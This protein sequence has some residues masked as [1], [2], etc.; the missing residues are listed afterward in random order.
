MW[1]RNLVLVNRRPPIPSVVS[2]GENAL[3]IAIV[4]GNEAMVRLLCE[5]CPAVLA[6][7]AVGS[8]FAPSGTCY[9]GELPLSFAVCTNQGS[10]VRLL[11]DMG[12]AIDAA[13]A[14]NGNTA[15][16]MAVLH[17]L[18]GMFDVLRAEW[19]RRTGRAGPCLSDRR[20][21]HGQTCLSLAAAEGSVEMFDHVLT[22]RGHRMWAFG[23]VTCTLYP[24][25]SLDT[26]TPNAMR[27][28]LEKGRHEL[29]RLPRIRRLQVS[30]ASGSLCLIKALSYVSRY[31]VD[32]SMGGWQYRP[33]TGAW[34]CRPRTLRK[35]GV[36]GSNSTCFRMNIFCYSKKIPAPKN[37]K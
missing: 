14:A 22:S 19:A 25:E 15:M 28:M 7:R 16:H 8:F 26:G 36:P 21:R 3:H 31:L 24:I 34:V 30:I 9:Y 4:N 27:Y 33:G 18:T 12:A 35:T 11:L 2:Q 32:M 6:H 5:K 29:L 20:N 1:P 23:A 17:D 10:M 37:A 13:D